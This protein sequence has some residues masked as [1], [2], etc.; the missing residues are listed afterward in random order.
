MRVH[1]PAHICFS[2]EGSSLADSVVPFTLHCACV[3]TTL[4]KYIL[5]E[6]HGHRIAVILNEFGEETGIESAFVQDGQVR[7]WH[8]SRMADFFSF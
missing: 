3:Q 6:Q 8:D 4:V 7:C 2:A 5:E 1:V